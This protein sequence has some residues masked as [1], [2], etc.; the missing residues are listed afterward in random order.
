[1]TI[2][3]QTNMFITSYNTR[4]GWTKIL[5]ELSVSTIRLKCSCHLNWWPFELLLFNCEIAQIQ[6]ENSTKKKTNLFSLKHL[7]YKC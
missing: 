3:S 1:M 4:E 7:A 6:G 2:E 5:S